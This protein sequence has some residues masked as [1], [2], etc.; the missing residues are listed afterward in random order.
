MKLIFTSFLLLASAAAAGKPNFIV[1]VSDDQDWTGLSV[2]MHPGV[3]NS[4]SDFF[5]TPNLEKFASQGLRFSNGYAPAPVCSPTRISLQTGK[6]PARLRWT[7]A[8]PPEPGHRLIEAESRKNIAPDEVTLAEMLKSVGYAT[9]HFGKWHLG[10]GGPE[11][12]GYDVSDG[13]TGNRDADPFVDPNPDDVFGMADRAE[14]FLTKQSSS[15]TPFYLQ[16]SWYPLHMPQNALRETRAFYEKQPPGQMHQ[17]IDV[18]AI[19]ENLDTGVGR[20]L[21][22]VTRLHLTE[23]TYIVYLSDNGAGGG[24]KG[25]IRPLS[26]GKGGV[27]EGGIRVPFLVCGPGVPANSWC[28]VPVV[29][30]DLFPTFCKLAGV[31]APMPSDLDG[32]DL[33]ALLQGTQAP[34]KR[35]REDLVF[36]FPHYQGDAPHS[37]I[38]AGN[39]KLLHFYET[40]E[41]RLYDLEADLAERNDLS[42]TK[43]DVTEALS[44]RLAAYLNEVDAAMPAPNPNFDPAAEPARKGG[45]NK[46]KPKRPQ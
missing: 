39:Y 40:G 2:A 4:R 46:G 15:G 22:A 31:T 5:R 11:A 27:W 36:H 26:A 25:G 21:D 42:K 37:A 35:P 16:L 17:N 6:T 12:H 23:T 45:R 34:V 3:A 19:T 18:A 33:S 20:V 10:G 13:D 30:F 8:A 44:R 43:P 32:G 28:H 7:K 1:M 14:A 29:A 9:A 41:N 38:R 24:G